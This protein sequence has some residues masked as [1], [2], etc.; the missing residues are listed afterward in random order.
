MNERNAHRVL[1]LGAAVLVLAA[2][3]PAS[4]SAATLDDLELGDLWSGEAWD[5][6]GL[7]DRTVVVEFW[8]YN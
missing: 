1:L 8:G 3:G 7:K 4:A 5:L 6:E 2:L